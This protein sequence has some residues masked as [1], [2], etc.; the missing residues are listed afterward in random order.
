VHAVCAGSRDG[1][2]SASAEQQAPDVSV[3]EPGAAAGAAIPVLSTDEML[4]ASRAKRAGSDTSH[5][6]ALYS[7][8]FGGITTDPA[9]MM[10]PLDDHGMSRGHCMFDT[11]SFRDG[12]F[13]RLGTHVDRL[14]RN[15]DR[16]KVPHNFSRGQIIETIRQT[17]AAT[18][19][20]NGAVRYYLTAG[21]GGCE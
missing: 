2:A 20:H 1:D 8:Y 14:L 18:G 15:C 10:L 21:H 7:S 17:V 5:M 3:D 6:V 19:L 9:M 4:A 11:G 12:R 16:G 13:Y